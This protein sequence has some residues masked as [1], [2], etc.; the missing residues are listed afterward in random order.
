MYRAVRVTRHAQ[1]RT[2]P[3]VSGVWRVLEKVSS[4]L[5]LGIRYVF[6][7]LACRG[8]CHRSLYRPQGYF[9]PHGFRPQRGRFSSPA[10]GFQLAVTSQIPKRRTLTRL[11]NVFSPGLPD[12]SHYHHTVGPA[13][14]GHKSYDQELEWVSIILI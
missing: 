11:F 2:I 10:R 5:P 8:I 6:Y 7:T 3:A 12:G 1:A 13:R 9:R 14:A 4:S